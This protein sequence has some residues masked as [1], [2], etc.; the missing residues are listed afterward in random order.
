MF[1][2]P[3]P[4]DPG[5]PDCLPKRQPNPLQPD[6]VTLTDKLTQI[7]QFSEADMADTAEL[8]LRKLIDELN[9]HPQRNQDGKETDNR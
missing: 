2:L 1:N 6:P 4:Y 7:L 9:Q 8:F 3:D 5:D